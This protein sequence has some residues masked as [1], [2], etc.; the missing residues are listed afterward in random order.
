[1]TFDI[2]FVAIVVRARLAGFHGDIDKRCG[3][4]KDVH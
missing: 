4:A 1:V 3:R 2:A